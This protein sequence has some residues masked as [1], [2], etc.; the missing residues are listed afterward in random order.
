MD[1]QAKERLTGGLILVALMV[2]VVPEMLSGPKR[3][4]RPVAGVISQGEGT[5]PLRTYTL[6]LGNGNSSSANQSNLTPESSTDSIP[7]NSTPD[8]TPAAPVEVAPP[9]VVVPPAVAPPAVVVPP[10]VTPPAVT[11]PA[12]AP[13]QTRA[14]AGSWWVQVGSYSQGV[15]AAR[16]VRELNAR[17]ISA[18]QSSSTSNGRTLFRVRAG[19]VADRAAAESLRARLSQLGHQGSLVAP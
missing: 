12:P 5:A 17:G 10:A 11:A 9:A 15:N 6:E 16:V 4:N 18:L 13:T 7:L 14:I 8:P 3:T 2:I 1:T 19:P